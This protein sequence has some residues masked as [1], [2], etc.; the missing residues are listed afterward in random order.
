MNKKDNNLLEFIPYKNLSYI[1]DREEDNNR[2]TI[3]IKRNSKIDKII[4][5]I[6]RKAHKEL[7]V[8]L[9]E[10]GSFI[11]RNID[12]KKTVLNLCEVFMREHN[13]EQSEA[14]NRTVYFLKIL[15]NNKFIKFTVNR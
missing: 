5:K 6:F 14:I 12:G 4:L 7:Y 8:H 9:D 3:I 13:V 2:I 11:W 15:K 10:I 1:S